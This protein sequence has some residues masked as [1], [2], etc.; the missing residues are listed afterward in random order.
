MFI[1]LWRIGYQRVVKML[2]PEIFENIAYRKEC[3][4]DKIYSKAIQA[5]HKGREIV[6]YGEGQEANGYKM[7]AA[8]VVLVFGA[9]AG[10][11]ESAAVATLV[12]FSAGALLAARCGSPPYTGPDETKDALG[13]L[14]VLL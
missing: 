1:V 6:D 3:Y 11:G 10:V 12:L 14:G 2:V 7:I 8:P 4:L 9:F 13:G 5:Y